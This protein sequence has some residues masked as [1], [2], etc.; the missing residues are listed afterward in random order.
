MNLREDKG[1]AYGA[2][3]FTS[4]AKGQRPWFIYAPVQTDKTIDS[5]KEILKEVNGYQ[6]DQPA[7]VDE[8]EKIVNNNVNS[9]PGQFETAGAVLGAMQNNH[10]FD[11]PD[12][13]VTQLPS[14]YRGL[15]LDDIHAAA[16][17]ELHPENLVWVV[18]GDREKIADGLA[19]VGFDAIRYI[20]A[21][22][23]I[24]E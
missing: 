21:D 24:V 9:L 10:I 7:R 5:I 20:D 6:G 1:W 17:S 18:V 11:R 8:L 3:T 15:Q 4:N 22:G 2:Y 14:A 12:N 13:Y 19:D 23:N 16:R